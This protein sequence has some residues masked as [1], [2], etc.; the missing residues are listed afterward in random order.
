MSYGGGGGGMY[1]GGQPA[2]VYGGGGSGSEGPS[3]LGYGGQPLGPAATPSYQ[4]GQGHSG[5]RGYDDQM[6]GES[7]SRY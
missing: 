6:G 5:M 7:D 4:Q 3:S 2:V 1:G